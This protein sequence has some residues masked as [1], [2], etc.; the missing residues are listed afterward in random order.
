ML[1]ERALSSGDV[2]TLK[3][4][5]GEEL[6]A[7]FEEETD[8]GFKISKPM[9][10]AMGPNGPGLIPYLFTVNPSKSITVDKRAVTVAVATEKQFA[11]QYLS[12][13]TSIQMV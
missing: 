1:I 7:R 13:T 2:V 3:L 11:D 6:V 5:N 9:V 10:I 12:S 4:F 8:Q